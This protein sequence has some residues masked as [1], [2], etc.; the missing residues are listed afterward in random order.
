MRTQ[1]QT[2]TF[3][4]KK[5]STVICSCSSRVGRQRQEGSWDLLTSYSC[6]IGEQVQWEGLSEKKG[7]RVIS[8]SDRKLWPA[9]AHIY[10]HICTCTHLHTDTKVSGFSLHKSRQKY[11][12]TAFLPLTSMFICLSFDSLLSILLSDT[13]CIKCVLGRPCWGANCLI[14][15]KLVPV[16]VSSGNRVQERKLTLW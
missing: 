13:E 4:W 10:A 16:P 8:M 5:W 1:V 14:R 15:R 3:I 11:F 12:L 2:T 6:Q 9:Q 7:C